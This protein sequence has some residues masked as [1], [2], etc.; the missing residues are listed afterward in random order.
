VNGL[1]AQCVKFETVRGHNRESREICLSTL[2]NTPL[3]W[4]EQGSDENRE[5]EW[6]DYVPFRKGFY[7][8]HLVVKERGAKT[9]EADIEFQD[10]HELPPNAFQIPSGMRIRKACEHFVDA[11][12]IKDEDPVYPWLIGRPTVDADVVVEVKVSV[13]GKVDAA[14]ITETGGA[15]FDV[16]AMNAVKKWAFEPAKCDGEPVAHKIS[17]KVHFHKR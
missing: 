9:I 3:R 8:R 13:D 16:A 15:D 11:V 17:V 6:T 12:V 4:F 14:Q 2:N 7:P 10:A 5:F 1:E